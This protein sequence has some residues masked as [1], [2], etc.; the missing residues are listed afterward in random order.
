VRNLL[1]LKGDDPS[2]GDQPDAKPVFDLDSIGLL[3]TAVG[4]RD[5]GELPNGRKVTGAAEFLVGVADMPVDPP[6]GWSPV[7]LLKKITA[8]A[9]F[10]QTQFCMDVEIARKYVGRLHEL[11]ITE[12][13]SLLIGVGA[14]AS[15]RSARWMQKHLF[16]TIVPDAL[17]ERMEAASDPRAEGQRICV[18]LIQQLC[19]IPGLAGVHIMAPL[20][21]G[22]IPLIV[23]ACRNLGG[24]RPVPRP[25]DVLMG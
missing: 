12:R 5:R 7:G 21:E 25:L 1:I 3:E 14:I 4:I 8:G 16:G 24:R 15:A 13:L 11:G 22:A 6:L 10:A 18:E 23:A 20:N 17:I 19:E 2:A 9:Q